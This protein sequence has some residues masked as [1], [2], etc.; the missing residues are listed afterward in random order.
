[1]KKCA[2]NFYNIAEDGKIAPDEEEDF[3]EVTKTL[4]K[5]SVS[6]SELRLLKEKILR[7]ND[8]LDE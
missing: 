4:D 6:I 8:G 1:M 2:E 3:L 7:R 5:L